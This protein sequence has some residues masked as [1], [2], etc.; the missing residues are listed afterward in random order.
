MPYQAGVVHVGELV[1]ALAARSALT[2]LHCLIDLHCTSRRDA[3][4]H[5]LQ[6]SVQTMLG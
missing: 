1:A 2:G 4:L 6:H 3:S 5:G